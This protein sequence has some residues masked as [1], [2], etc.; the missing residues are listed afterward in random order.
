MKVSKV[1]QIRLS[2]AMANLQHGLH[3]VRGDFPGVRSVE[4]AAIFKESDEAASCRYF[5]FRSLPG[6]T[7]NLV[8]FRAHRDLQGSHIGGHIVYFYNV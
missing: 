2:N 6:D 1:G 8:Q 3:A 4:N 5:Q 7:T